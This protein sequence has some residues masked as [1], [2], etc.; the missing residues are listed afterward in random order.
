MMAQ[1]EKLW[2]VERQNWVDSNVIS[3]YC[4]V[5]PSQ[6]LYSVVI[7]V[8]SIKLYIFAEY[9]CNSHYHKAALQKTRCGFI[10]IYNLY[11]ESEAQ[12]KTLKL[13]DI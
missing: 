2:Y 5:K 12:K 3:R 9:F 8:N 7:L 11:I 10:R 1:S 13:Y 6:Y 4:I